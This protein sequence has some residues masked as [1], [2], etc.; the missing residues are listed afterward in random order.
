VPNGIGRKVVNL[1]S[2]QVLVHIDTAI[3]VARLTFSSSFSFLFFGSLP[4]HM[5]HC[6]QASGHGTKVANF[7]SGFSGEGLVNFLLKGDVFSFVVGSVSLAVLSDAVIVRVAVL[8]I[9]T[10]GVLTFALNVKILTR[11]HP[12]MT[13][14]DEINTSSTR[15]FHILA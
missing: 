1:N 6:V 2:E 9:R 7:C 13:V 12:S 5:R 11:G 3:I 4:L 15:G 10:T 8:F 14:F